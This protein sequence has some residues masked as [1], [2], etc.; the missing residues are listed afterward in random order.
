MLGILD[1]VFVSVGRE[2]ERIWK[3]AV[4]G[5]FSVKTFY[6]VLADNSSRGNGWQSFWDPYVPPR[7][8]VFCRVTRKHKI[9][10]IDKLQRR[11]HFLVNGCPMCLKDEETAHH[12][13]IHCQ[14]AYKV[15]MAILNFFEMS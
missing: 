12:L 1:N 2:D 10:T 15:R 13:L 9:M 3:P 7:V 8:S 4:K 5:Q 6:N 11:K 14:F